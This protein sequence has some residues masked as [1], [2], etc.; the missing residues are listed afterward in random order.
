MESDAFFG[1]SYRKERLFSLQRIFIGNHDYFFSLWAGIWL[2]YFVNTTIVPFASM[3]TLFTIWCLFKRKDYKSKAYTSGCIITNSKKV[4]S[5]HI[6]RSVI[7]KEL[8]VFMIIDKVKSLSLFY[9]CRRDG[10]G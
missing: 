6:N 2:Y 5:C 9:F 4:S 7:H 10:L 3:V 1:I 8:T